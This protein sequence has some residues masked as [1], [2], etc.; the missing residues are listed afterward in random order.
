MSFDVTGLSLGA[1][2]A[3]MMGFLWFMVK[4]CPYRVYLTPD[5]DSATPKTYSI[6]GLT[7]GLKT[8]FLC[9]AV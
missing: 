1:Y 5:S 3:Q 7:S 4:R 6:H 2:I 8:F 9:M